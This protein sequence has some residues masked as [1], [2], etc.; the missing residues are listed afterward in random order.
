MNKFELSFSAL[1]VPVDILMIVAAAIAAYSIRVSPY[2]AEIRP[3][4]Y[5]LSFREYMSTVFVIMP[6]W[7]AIFAL[8]GLYNLKVTRRLIQ[9]FFTVAIAASGGLMVIIIM[10]F[11]RR[12]L[13]SSR[14]IILIGWILSIVCVTIGRFLIRNLQKWLVKKYNYGIHQV[15]LV[16][17]NG[18]KDVLINYFTRDKGM[19]YRVVGSLDSF[20]YAE[21]EK[22]IQE[23]NVNEIIQCD[24][25]IG[26]EKTKSLLDLSDEYKIDFKF[27][28]DT[29]GTYIN[30]DIRT[31]SGIPIVEIKKTSLDGWGKIIKRAFDI[32]V[33][34]II[35][36]LVSP[37][38]IITA[39]AVKMNSSG[40]I[41]FSRLDDG[42][43]LTRIGAKGKPFRYFKFR[44]MY[45]KV[46]NMRYHELASQNVRSGP[47][48]KIGNDPRITAV[49]KFIRR[50][51]IDELPELFLVLWGKMSLVGPRPHFPEE[52]A[53]YEKH[54][55]KV[56][57]IKPG[58]TGLAQISGRSDLDFE[59]E[60][61]LDTYYIENWS[62]KLDLQI[63]LK[64]PLAVFAK[65]Q[66]E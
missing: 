60:V 48:V 33:S 56:L 55:K 57:T 47:L 65:R 26:K 66:A 18:V 13:F 9:E 4:I 2:V 12:E 32:V 63:L 14:F 20:E 5:D 15:L 34:F 41:F 28:P 53:K 59:E 10:I 22:I 52:V 49:G 16:G 39:I 50:F 31:I 42:K 6:F 61:K 58:I 43:P 1:L 46:H 44:S 11:L 30:F 24:P 25:Q 29:F 45:K 36:V 21:V 8:N 23:N 3:V 35:I 37:I 17:G 38:M 7:V 27:I 54:H 51:S 64:T 19:G 62:L 40:P